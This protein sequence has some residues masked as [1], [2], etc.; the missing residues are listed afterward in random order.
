MCLLTLQCKNGLVIGK[1]VLRLMLLNFQCHKSGIKLTCLCHAICFLFELTI[2]NFFGLALTKRV[3]VSPAFSLNR[4][5]L[6]AVT[7][8][9]RPS[10][11]FFPFEK[12]SFGGR[13]S[14]VSMTIVVFISSPFHSH[15]RSSFDNLLVIQ[16]QL[17]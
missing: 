3:S 11:I 8:H 14:N 9:T 7:S 1:H 6:T 17:R 2:A 13:Q 16:L 4:V 15:V 12:L 5:R 10:T